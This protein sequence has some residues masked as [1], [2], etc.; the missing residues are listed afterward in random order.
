[1]KPVPPLL[2]RRAITVLPFLWALQRTAIAQDE[3]VGTSNSALE[4]GP[5]R[6]Q[7]KPSP[8]RGE[9]VI[10][11]PTR[12]DVGYSVRWGDGSWSSYKIPP[13]YRRRHWHKLDANGRAPRPQL[14][15][16]NRANDHQYTS[17]T[18]E[19]K[20]GRAGN[21]P[22]TGAVDQSIHYEFVANG[23]LIDLVRR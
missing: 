2:R 8:F 13:Q 4:E 17:K 18:Y 3:D 11:N 20:F 21:T 19:M 9:F 16:D 5:P 7:N 6:P 12:F 14:K 10:H 23:S 1:M 22:S 15:F